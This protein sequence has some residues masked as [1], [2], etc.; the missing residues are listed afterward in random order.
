MPD[1]YRWSQWRAAAC[2][3]GHEYWP[4]CTCSGADGDFYRLCAFKI[5][6]ALSLLLLERW[7]VQL[8]RNPSISLLRQARVIISFLWR[9]WAPL[10][11][12]L[13]VELFLKIWWRFFFGFFAWLLWTKKTALT[14]SLIHPGCSIMI[15]AAHW[16]TVTPG[17]NIFPSSCAAPL[18]HPMGFDFSWANPGVPV[19]SPLVVVRVGLALGW[20]VLVGLSCASPLVTRFHAAMR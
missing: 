5:Q 1:R 7:L 17:R 18:N 14:A 12:L 8:E 16:G 10:Q 15:R 6:A 4:G 13:I 9:G 2:V 20:G 11:A 3:A 19:A